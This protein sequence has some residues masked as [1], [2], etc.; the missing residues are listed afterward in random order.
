[1]DTRTGRIYTTKEE[2][3]ESLDIIKRQKYLKQINI[4][5]TDRQ[6]KRNPPKIGRNEPCGCGSGKKFK[7]CCW[8]G[9]NEYA[10]NDNLTS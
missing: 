2:S 4:P 8:M 9:N 1:M 5:V 7:Y 10:F 6:M 3:E